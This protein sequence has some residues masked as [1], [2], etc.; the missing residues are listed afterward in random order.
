VNFAASKGQPRTPPAVSKHNQRYISLVT[1]PGNAD[2]PHNL[3]KEKPALPIALAG[4]ILQSVVSARSFVFTLA[5]KP[6]DFLP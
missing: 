4:K 3:Q 5:L 2:Q 6:I 1:L